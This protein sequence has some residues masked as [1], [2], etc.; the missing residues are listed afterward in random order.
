MRLHL[1]QEKLLKLLKNNISD[2]LSIREL[3]Q[4]IGAS[5]PSVVQHH[6]KQLEKKGYLRRNPNNPQDYQILHEP[7]NDI[8][9]LNLYGMAQ[10]GPNGQLLDG[11]PIDRIAV[12]SPLLSFPASDA[13]LVKAHG[14]SMKPE[15]NSGD[16]II[17]KKSLDIPNGGI[18][19]CVNDEKV[20]VKRI[21]KIHNENGSITYNL[22]SLNPEFPPFIAS[23][24]FHIEG[25]VKGVLKYTQ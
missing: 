10:C 6:L 23:T 22:I 12:Y 5:S 19:V 15:I 16:M 3:Q 17:A 8:A 1:A 24:N 13:F 9:Y 2:P 20:L 14:D 18:A 4:E 7:D 21:Q 25:I 11:N